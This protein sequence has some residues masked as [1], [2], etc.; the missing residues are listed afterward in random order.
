MQQR[1]SDDDVGSDRPTSAM[2]TFAIIILYEGQA[3][4]FHDLL[5]KRRG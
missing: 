2:F 1:R 3:L 5:D 4:E